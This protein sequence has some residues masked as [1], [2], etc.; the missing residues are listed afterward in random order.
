M[1]EQVADRVGA[2]RL[3]DGEDNEVALDDDAAVDEQLTGRE[4]LE[5]VGKLT[6]QPKKV[7]KARADE[8]LERLQLGARRDDIPTTFSRGLRQKAAIALGMVRP[9]DVL[10]VDEPFVGLDSN[11]KTTLLEL[12][13]EAAQVGATLLVATH[14]L[15]FV[16]R[17]GRLL[18]LRDVCPHRA[19]PV[20]AGASV[21]Q[22][23]AVRARMRDLAPLMG[24]EPGD[25]VVEA[26]AGEFTALGLA[27]ESVTVQ[28][29]SLPE[30]L[31]KILDQKIGMGMVGNDMGKFMQYQTAQAIPKFAEGAANGGGADAFD[32]FVSSMNIRWCY[33]K[34]TQ[35]ILGQT[36]GMLVL[37]DFDAVTPQ[38]LQQA[39]A[40][41]DDFALAHLQIH[42][43]KDV[44]FAVKGV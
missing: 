35:R 10:L 27:L 20:S 9:F 34:E 23:D 33:Y 38:L 39:A 40:E 12:L 25:A 18:A 21:A 44:A 26:T 7:I 29:V 11:G 16:G 14:E 24:R 2:E 37:Q 5:L 22:P 3:A 6:H 42:T 41:G 32:L 13:D 4:N 15:A 8:L 30:E 1:H 19:A 17:V 28:S 43:V 36:F 31:Q